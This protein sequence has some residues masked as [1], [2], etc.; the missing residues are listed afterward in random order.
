MLTYP[1][2]RQCFA[3]TAL[4][5]AFVPKSATFS[6]LLILRTRSLWD[7]TSSSPTGMP[8]LFAPACRILAC[9]ECFQWLSRQWPAL[10]SSET[11]DL[12]TTTRFLLIRTLPMLLRVALPLRC[13]LR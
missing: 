4:L 1:S 5:S 9:G 8:H 12:S 10:D 11:P 2:V 7:V 13:Y 6:P 3:I